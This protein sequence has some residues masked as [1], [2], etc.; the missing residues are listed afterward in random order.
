MNELAKLQSLVE[1]SFRHNKQLTN[2]LTP[3]T[4][5]QLIIAKLPQL[6]VLNKSRVGRNRPG[7]V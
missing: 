3:Q 6:A 2:D 1:L 5:N 4:A 7:P